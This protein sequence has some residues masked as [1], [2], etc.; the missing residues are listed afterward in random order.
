M[1]IKMLDTAMK[2]IGHL[3]EYRMVRPLGVNNTMKIARAY[4]RLKFGKYHAYRKDQYLNH[5]DEL[6]RENGLPS[7]P[8]KE[9]KDGWALD[10]SGT[11]PHLKQL[12]ADA[13]EI[14]KERGG[15][16]RTSIGRPWTQEIPIDD[17]LFKYPSILD[18]ATSS[19]VLSVVCNYLG[20]IPVFSTALP[21]GVRFVESWTKFDDNPNGPLRS[22]QLFHL[23]FHDS[24][25]IYVVVTVRDVTMENG[26]FVFC[27]LLSLK[28]LQTCLRVI[29]Q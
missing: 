9:L 15:V 29:I 5:F 1:L 3:L 22:S 18:F 13:E 26:P 24:P 4:N 17:L 28:K 7:T 11:V 8:P 27:P 21:R 25:M 2:P 23:D 10:T 19:G 6:I 12:L 20:Y 16:K 14:I